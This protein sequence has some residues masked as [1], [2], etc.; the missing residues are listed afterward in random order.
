MT[1]GSQTTS[2]SIIIALCSTL[3]LGSCDGRMVYENIADVPDKEWKANAPVNFAIP[4][5]DTISLQNIL[6]T[7]QNATNYKY[8]NL[9]LFVT[10]TSPS[11][12]TV[13]DTLEVQLADDKGRWYGKG[14]SRYYDLRVPYKHLI[15][16]PLKGDYTI[17]IA[18]GMREESLEGIVKVGVRVEQAKNK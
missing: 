9:F 17:S 10:T 18:Q 12:A 6:I 14:F 2:L 13:C 11:G 16:F 4:V 8:S 5:D 15:K 7:V 3:F 1:T